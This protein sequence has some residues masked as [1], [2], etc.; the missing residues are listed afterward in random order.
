MLELS[1]EFIYRRISRIPRLL[2]N[3]NPNCHLWFDT[4]GW[5]KA[6]LTW[7]LTDPLAKHHWAKPRG[8]PIW[9]LAIG[10]TCLLV[11]HLFRT[12]GRLSHTTC[13]LCIST[14]LFMS[15]GL[16]EYNFASGYLYTKI[17]LFTYYSQPLRNEDTDEFEKWISNFVS[18]RWSKL[19]RCLIFAFRVSKSN[20]KL[21]N[22]VMCSE[23]QLSV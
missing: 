15:F 3:E 14:R 6:A 21:I 8:A 17:L 22:F 19:S 16:G 11:R 7:A 23:L 5:A 9:P 18:I 13:P 1:E 20:K 2:E 10:Y 4:R 12:G